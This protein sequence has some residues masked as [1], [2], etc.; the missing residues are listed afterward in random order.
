MPQLYLLALALVSG[1]V[2]LIADDRSGRVR[3]LTRR[4]LAIRL[5]RAPFEVLGGLAQGGGEAMRFAASSRTP[6]L[7]R[8]DLTRRTMMTVRPTPSSLL[9]IWPGGDGNVGGSVTHISGILDGFRRRGMRI[10]LVTTAPPPE[11]LAAVVET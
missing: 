9:E 10:G 7:K 3:R 5:S 8:A 11:Q 2:R 1:R 6:S 4:R